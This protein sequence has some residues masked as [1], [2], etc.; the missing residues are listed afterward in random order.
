MSG[1]KTKNTI[2][3]MPLLICPNS[4]RG[5]FDNRVIYSTIVIE[6]R[7]SEFPFVTELSNV[8]HSRVK[9][10]VFVNLCVFVFVF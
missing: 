8:E 2:N 5:L 10:L 3:A 9:I 4:Q 6:M 1:Y 7:N